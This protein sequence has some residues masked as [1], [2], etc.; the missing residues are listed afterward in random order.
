MHLRN[1]EFHVH[2]E[3]PSYPMPSIPHLAEIF[4]VWH[5]DKT[6]LDTDA[7]F[8]FL[9][10]NIYLSSLVVY[11]KINRINLTFPKMPNKY[12]RATFD[13]SMGKFL[14]QSHQL[15]ENLS[16]FTNYLNKQ[17]FSFISY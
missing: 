5:I 8:L 14:L 9:S 11:V 10:V 3:F 1:G 4:S 6:N 13:I 17:S 15:E 2:S 16:A 12:L 7:G